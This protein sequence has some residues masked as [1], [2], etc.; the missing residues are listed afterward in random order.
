LLGV[1]GAAR[2]GYCWHEF[3]V[4][5]PVALAARQA[6]GLVLAVEGCGR[7]AHHRRIHALERIYAHHRVAS[8]LDVAR[9]HRHDAAARAHVELRGARAEL[10][11]GDARW[12]GDPHAKPSLGIRSPDAAMLH[13]EGAT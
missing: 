5:D 11:L 10:V 6:H 4:A 1:I 3:H 8:P 2:S 9:D 12:I 7:L 13:A